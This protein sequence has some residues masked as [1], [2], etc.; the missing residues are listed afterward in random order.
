VL[1][2]P[3]F[4]MKRE[5][6]FNLILAFTVAVTNE[7]QMSFFSS[8]LAQSLKVLGPQKEFEK[9]FSLFLIGFSI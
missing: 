6:L 3:N 2:D 7:R 4:G 1:A 5:E 8:L 9:L